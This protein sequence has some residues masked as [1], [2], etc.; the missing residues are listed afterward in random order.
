MKKTFNITHPKIKV[1]RLF[2]GV[3]HDVKKYIKRERNKK[4]PAGVDFW[5]FDSK[6]GIT[7][8]DAEVV[9]LSALN[10]HIDEAEKLGLTSFYVEIVVKEGFRSVKPLGDDE[11][12]DELDEE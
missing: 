1:A 4:L 8:A 9:H 7:E 5:D 12:F 11:D 6:Y 2:E 10:K 3:K